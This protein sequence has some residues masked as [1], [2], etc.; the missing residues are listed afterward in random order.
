MMSVKETAD[1]LGIKP[2]T[3]RHQIKNGKLAARKISR[4]WYLFEDEVERYRT[5]HLKGRAEA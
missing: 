3:V 1:A 5:V 2:S 4:D